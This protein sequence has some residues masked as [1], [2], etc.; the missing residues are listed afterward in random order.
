VTAAF[1]CSV[2]QDDC[3]NR[4]KMRIGYITSRFIQ[5]VVAE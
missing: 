3:R 1:G 4:D 5:F 2:E